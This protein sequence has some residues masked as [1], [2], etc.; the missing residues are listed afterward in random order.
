MF[1][2]AKPGAAELKNSSTHIG[3]IGSI[4]IWKNYLALGLPE[5][6]LVNLDNNR[7]LHG[8]TEVGNCCNNIYYITALNFVQSGSG[9]SSPCGI[10]S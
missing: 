5:L 9:I 3:T 6:K 4:D 7:T 1:D 2:I 8:P 10:H